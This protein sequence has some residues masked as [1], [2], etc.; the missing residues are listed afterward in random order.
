MMKVYVLIVRHFGAED[1]DVTN[2]NV[3]VYE[4][5]AG[6]KTRLMDVL[7]ENH[8]FTEPIPDDFV[9]PLRLR[10]PTLGTAALKERALLL[11][12]P[13]VLTRY[14]NPDQ[15]GISKEA[16]LEWRILKREVL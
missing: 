2:E 8:A 16:K 10:P 7:R 14:F 12:S 4:T 5:M 15:S 13:G 3:W 1:G 6:A 9:R 11:A